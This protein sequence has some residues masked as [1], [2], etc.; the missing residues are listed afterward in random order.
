MQYVIYQDNGGLFH[1]RLAGSDGAALAV[2]AVTFA[3]ADE[4]RRAATD[5][6]E[7]AASAIAPE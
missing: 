5:V 7:H 1:W 3:T 2:S 6:H 4:A